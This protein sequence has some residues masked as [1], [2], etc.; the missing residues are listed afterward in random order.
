MYLEKAMAPHSNTLAWKLPWMEE[1]GRLP[2][3]GS[4]KVR[5]DWATSLSLFYFMHR[6]RKW[7]LTPVF[8]PGKSHGRKSL[9][10]C[11]PWGRSESDPTERLHCH[12]SLSCI[13]GGHGNPLQCSCLE[14]PRD[15]WA[16]WAAVHGVTQTR[17]RLKRLSSSSSSSA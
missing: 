3:M 9:V 17:T 7:Q 10:G 1:P 16:W 2:S 12:I 4:L 14:S 5:Q 13:G 15:C 6:R 8:L 11:R